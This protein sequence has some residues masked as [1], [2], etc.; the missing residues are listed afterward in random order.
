[1]YL[2]RRV[3]VVMPVHNEDAHVE[4]ALERVP[5][6]VDLIVVV[7]DGSTDQTRRVLSHLADA[8]LTV[9]SHK[10]NRGVG[11]ATKTGYR[12]VLDADV[13]LIAVMD[14]DGQMDGCDLSHLLDCAINRADFVKGNRF[15][16]RVSIRTMPR[17]R[18][19]GNRFFS[20]L[21][22]RAASYDSGLDAHCGYTVIRKH[23]LRLLE[24]NELYDRY[25]FPTEMFLAA[26]RAGLVV[27]SVPVR[28]IYGDEVSGVNPLTTI[29][30]IFF[31]IARGY[32]RR[33]RS[34]VKRK[35]GLNFASTPEN[36]EVHLEA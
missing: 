13:E 32:I 18:Y 34:D 9:L 30:A 7:D 27:K 10:S 23:A 15:L 16:D 22:R 4:R 1:M 8:R 5:A 14:G 2:D 11:A 26:C 36:A 3:A 21:A 31:L 29:P 17:L 25:G 35:T 6:Y 33:R 12:Y 20:W 28:T 19:F 24:L